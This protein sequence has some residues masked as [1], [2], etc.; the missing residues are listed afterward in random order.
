[1]NL[2]PMLLF[3]LF[4][5]CTSVSATTADVSI[6][7]ETVVLGEEVWIHVDIKPNE[8]AGVGAQVSVYEVGEE[9]GVKKWTN[10][11]K[12]MASGCSICGTSDSITSELDRN[13]IFTPKKEGRY[14]VDLNL[15]GAS[16]SIRKTIYF[17]VA[18]EQIPDGENEAM[19]ESMKSGANETKT[20]ESPSV[21]ENKTE[22]ETL[23]GGTGN[24]TEAEKV[25]VNE[26]AGPDADN[27]T[28]DAGK[29]IGE[30]PD[31]SNSATIK[32]ILAALFIVLAGYMLAKRG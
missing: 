21:F 14:V 18:G 24:S 19:N 27:A 1:M 22:N 12:I 31:Y 11:R 10:E 15:H 7:N 30:R 4:F 26:T 17:T 13:Y 8:S 25:T 16:G 3:A 2:K 6:S 20:G 28:F 29:P 5:M 32:V 23:R 9:D